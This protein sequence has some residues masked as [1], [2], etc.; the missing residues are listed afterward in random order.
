MDVDPSLPAIALPIVEESRDQLWNKA[1]F[2]LR[3]IYKH[4]LA[5]YDW[6]FKADDDT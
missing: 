2:T 6:F 4:H 5:D 1:K 3:Y